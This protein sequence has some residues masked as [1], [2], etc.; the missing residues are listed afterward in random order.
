VPRAL[1]IAALSTATLQGCG[2][3]AA[4]PVGEPAERPQRAAQ[5]P[6]VVSADIAAAYAARGHRPL[7][8]AGGKLSADGQRLL[9]RLATAD[10]EG[11]DPSR[12]GLAEIQAAVAAPTDQASLARADLLLTRAFAAYLRDLHRPVRGMRYIDKE[13]APGPVDPAA[14]LASPKPA[15]A[16]RFNPLYEALRRAAVTW[17][18]SNPA[19]SPSQQALVQAN[20]QRARAIPAQTGRYIIVDTGSARLWMIDGD[21]VEGP[22]RTIVGRPDMQ[23][24]AIAGLI[25]YVTLNPYWNVPPDL[26]RE[27]ARRVLKQGTGFLVRDR[28]EVL[29]DWGDNASIMKLAQVNWRAAADGK[30]KL[31]MRQLPGGGNVM[32]AMKFMMPNELGIYLHDFPDKA[33]FARRERSISSGCVRVADAQR[34]AAWLFGGRAPQPRGAAPEQEVD[35]PEPVPVYLTYLTV[36][37]A[38]GGGLLFE[39]DPYRRDQAALASLERNPGA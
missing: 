14:A 12:Y 16:A 10:V 35:L 24:P 25:R 27:R 4:R 21:T 17:R 39:D 36:L 6:V 15:D 13:I 3:E 37:P 33:L 5:A 23:T 29:S 8:L 9:Q 19:A 11:L 20:L 2:N 31:R 38:K 26:A 7:W 1:L 34:L 18:A 22:M 32:G 30:I 28:I